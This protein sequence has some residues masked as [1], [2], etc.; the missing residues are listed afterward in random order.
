MGEQ[1]GLLQEGGK[2]QMEARFC[3][4]VPRLQAVS[5]KGGVFSHR[6]GCPGRDRRGSNG[7]QL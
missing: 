2:D 1:R 7:C 4:E 5:T 6:Q 3:D